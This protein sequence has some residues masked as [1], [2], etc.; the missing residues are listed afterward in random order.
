MSAHLEVLEP[1]LL[2]TVQDLGR[3]GYAHW[4][5]SRSG[6]ADRASARLANRLV[7]NPEG[8]ACLE[9]TLGGLR[10]R[11]GGD[12]V[13]A[14]TGAPCPA[15]AAG[16]DV[17]TNAAFELPS[18]HELTLAAPDR[19]LRTYL[20]VR[21]GLDVTAVLGS[22]ATDLLGGLGP[23]I[24]SS[25]DRLAVGDASADFPPVDHA[26]VREIPQGEVEL[27]VRFGPRAD[28]FTPAA[29]ER[30]V[31]EPW[32]AGADSNRIGLRLSGPH[33]ERRITDELP[34]EGLV[35]GA[36][37]VPPTGAPTIFLADHPVTGGYP[38]IA[39]VLDE[40]VDLAAQIR[41]GQT[42]RLRAVGGTPAV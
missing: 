24:V 19:G 27:R 20:A 34:S 14:A 13:L 26:A 41:P 15:V 29:R 3:P 36:L 40:D 35:R 1:G 25:G 16:M 42:V 38:V 17:A 6:A 10:V 5:V 37:Q 30:L 33:L 7:A 39:V 23:P 12:L 31:T 32:V 28:W 8:T 4:G 11:A 18:G 9:V 22:R 21:G 2:T